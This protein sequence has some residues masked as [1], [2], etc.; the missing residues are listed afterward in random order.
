MTNTTDIRF[1]RLEGCGNSF[2]VI[3]DLEGALLQSVG[4]VTPFARALQDRNFGWPGDGA[5]FVRRSKVAE[6]EMVGRNPDGSAM[7]MCGNGIRCVTRALYLWGEVPAAKDCIAFEVEGRRI[8]CRTQDQGRQVQVDMGA[9]SFAPV[10]IPVDSEGEFVEQVIEIEGRRFIAT[11]VS[12]GNPHCVIFDETVS[13]GDFHHFGPLLEHHP[14]FPRR[15]NIEFVTIVS[16]SQVR[17]RVWE[18]GAGPTLACGTGACAVVAAG[19]R[20]GRLERKV[21]VLLPGGAL[22]VEITAATALLTGPAC[23]MGSGVLASDFVERCREKGR[24]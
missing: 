15:A 14:L 18:R 3:A 22:Q 8:V 21:R 13:D 17:V 10:S 2:T 1:I 16:P 6:F 23:E 20:C 19:V 9:P 12:M 5:L 4:E 7:G 11:A 24:V